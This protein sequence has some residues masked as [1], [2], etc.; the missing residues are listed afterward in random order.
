ML[1]LS[2]VSGSMSPFLA[3]VWYLC[4]CCNVI[5]TDHSEVPTETSQNIHTNI[6]KS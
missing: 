4:T 2:P 1:R 5:V 6:F 3:N